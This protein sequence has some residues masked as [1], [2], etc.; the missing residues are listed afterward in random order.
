MNNKLY[1][2]T[3]VHNDTSITGIIV[4]VFYNQRNDTVYVLLIDANGRLQK[5]SI[6]QIT[7]T[8]YDYT[9]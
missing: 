1:G 7:V 5:Y 8:D 4:D 9:K 2:Y 6:Y 3:A